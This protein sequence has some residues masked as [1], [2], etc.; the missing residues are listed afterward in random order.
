[1]QAMKPISALALLAILGFTVAGCGSSRKAGPST[2]V[3]RAVVTVGGPELGP[4]TVTGP[5]TTTIPNVP[6]GTRITCRTRHG[7]GANVKVPR[8]GVTVA[9]GQS[10]LR[11]LGQTRTPTQQINL[12]HLEDGSITVSCSQSK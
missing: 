1:V 11:E 7:L 4:I 6:T 5:T 9:E 3:T 8:V 2:S 12:T 10:Q